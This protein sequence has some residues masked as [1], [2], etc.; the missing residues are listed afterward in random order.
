MFLTLLDANT[1]RNP[2]SVLARFPYL[3]CGFSNVDCSEHI[4]IHSAKALKHIWD[5]DLINITCNFLASAS[6]IQFIITDS[7]S[8]NSLGKCYVLLS[9]IILY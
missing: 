7:N 5:M 8:E 6:T 1:K 3:E 9:L 4:V 2:Y